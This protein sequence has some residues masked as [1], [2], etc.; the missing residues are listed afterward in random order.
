MDPTIIIILRV[1]HIV[2]GAIWLGGAVTVAFFL[3]PTVKATGPVGGQFIGA[4][5]QRTH[6][7][8]WLLALG[9]VNIIA[10]LILYWDL[11]VGVPWDT[12]G[13]PGVYAIGGVLA[14][15]VVVFGFA[16]A[17]PT[18]DRLAG[19]GK[20]IQAQ[21]SPPTPAQAADREALL[22]RLTGVV[23]LNA[24]LLIITGALMAIGRYA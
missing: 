10:G 13:P 1:I 3:L 16:I 17:R 7:P 11:Y 5:V 6:L 12:F 15:L 9:V 22:A 2:A 8:E 24:I 19:L 18:A 4:L 20:A 21:G 14:V 23:S